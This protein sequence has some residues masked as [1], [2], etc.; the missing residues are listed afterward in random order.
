[1]KSF[2]IIKKHELLYVL[3]FFNNI[4]IHLTFNVNLLR[5]NLNNSLLK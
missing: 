4:K 2:R 5:K 1:M 3:N